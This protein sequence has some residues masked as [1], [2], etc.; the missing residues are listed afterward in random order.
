[1][2]FFLRMKKNQQVWVSS[3]ACP[4]RGNSGRNGHHLYSRP[5]ARLTS[6]P[7]E[8]TVAHLP[9]HTCRYQQRVFSSGMSYV[10]ATA[11]VKAM[12]HADHDDALCAGPRLTRFRR[13]CMARQIRNALSAHVLSHRARLACN[14][15]Q[16]TIEDRQTARCCKVSLLVLLHCITSSGIYLLLSQLRVSRCYSF[17]TIRRMRDSC[18][19]FVHLQCNTPCRLWT[20][21]EAWVQ[22]WC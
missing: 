14:R 3:S 13:S 2:N 1:M 8:T 18:L 6:S 9:E 11:H 20:H 12:Q 19:T 5:Q 16:T 15:G 22:T 10:L 21:S 4:P 7:P 17:P